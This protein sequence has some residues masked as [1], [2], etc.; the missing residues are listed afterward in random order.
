MTF[1]KTHIRD[2]KMAETYSMR[3]ASACMKAEYEGSV[4]GRPVLGLDDCLAMVGP[5]FDCPSARATVA[6]SGAYLPE[7]QHT[8]LVTTVMYNGLPHGLDLSPAAIGVASLVDVR[9]F[10]AT[11]LLGLSPLLRTPERRPRRS[12]ASRAPK[13]QAAPTSPEQRARLPC[14]Q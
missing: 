1:P 8:P 5:T 2:H 10:V 7:L 14:A 9:R 3:A 12:E 13:A 6:D 11:Q 4:A